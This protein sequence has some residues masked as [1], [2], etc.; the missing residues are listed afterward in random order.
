MKRREHLAGAIGAIVLAIAGL[1][2]CGS[3]GGTAG[4]E[5][6]AGASGATGGATPLTLA[7]IPKG[8][9]HEHWARVRIGAEKAA[10]EL[11]AAGTPVRIVWKGP[12]R[13]DDRE[14]QI[15]VVE[16]FVS[17]GVQGI[18]LAPLDSRALKRPVEEA[19]QRGHSHGRLR[20]RARAAASGRELREHRQRQGRAP[21][22]PAHGRAAEGQGHR[23]DAALPGGIGVH[24]G[25]R[26]G[27]P[28]RA[29]ER[30]PGRD[31]DLGGSVRRPDAR[32]GEAGVREPAQSLRDARRR[33]LHAQR[34]VD[35]RHAAR[36]AG[37]RQGRRDHL[38]RLRL[39]H[40]LPRAAA[41]G[42]AQGLRR[43]E[44][45]E[46]GLPEREDDGRAP[47]EAAGAGRAST[48]AWSW[49]RSTTSRIRRSRR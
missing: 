18:V 32:H 26:G 45:G 36:A 22:R 14:Q 12:I 24:G 2:G 31:G 5:G 46:H 40:Q 13:E 8:S 16:G 37:H 39:Q 35:R 49:S 11:T 27:L 33:H 9:T 17:Q 21:R 1:A 10:A 38:R 41:Q 29:E 4:G 3:P 48:P 15:Q 20:L 44:P 28:R 34:V 30:L 23:P 47:E 25:A 42:R 6:S 7:V 43:A 19:A